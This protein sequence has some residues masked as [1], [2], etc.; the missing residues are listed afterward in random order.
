MKKIR[1][2]SIPVPEQAGDQ[3][4]FC[5]T[6]VIERQHP[7]NWKPKPNQ[8][9]FY[10]KWLLCPKRKCKAIWHK[11]KWRRYTEKSWIGLDD[12]TADTWSQFEYA[13]SKDK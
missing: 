2:L 11:D 3:C 7:E 1:K 13:I 6:P 12:D 8:P 10:I 5:G 4:Y 9:F